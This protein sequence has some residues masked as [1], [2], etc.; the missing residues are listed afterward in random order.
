MSEVLGRARA[1]NL[2]EE[3]L[4]YAKADQTEVTFM[5]QRSSLTRFANNF[6]HQ[7][8]NENNLTIRV[9]AVYGQKIG[10]ATTNKL[11]KESLKQVVAEAEKLATLQVADPEFKSLPASTNSV[12]APE[13]DEDTYFCDPQV[14]ANGVG[15]ICRKSVEHN[16]TAAGAFETNGLEVAIGNSLGIRNYAR[17]AWSHLNT[18]VMGENSSGWGERMARRVSDIDCE[19]IAEEAVGKAERSRNPVSLEPGD[20]EVLL[21]EYAVA[22]LL[23][24]MSFLG[25]GGLSLQEHRSFMQIGQKLMSNLVTIADDSSHPETLV[26][27][28][29]A[30]GVSRQKVTLIEQGIAKGVVYDSY[31]ANREPGKVNTG[32]STGEQGEVG[33]VPFNLIMENG[34]LSKAEMLK[35]I[36]RGLYVTR[37]HYVNPLVPDKA[38]LTGMTRDGTFLIENGEIVGPVR[39]FRFTQSAVEALNNVVAVSRERKLLPFFGTMS[40]LAPA[41]HTAKFT[42]NSA[43]AF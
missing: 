4:G 15:A 40:T 20:Y 25:F 17:T 30:E 43:T 39:N 24:Y 6:I 13:P 11:D 37:F 28:F 38:V 16:F 33:P 1:L 31:T 12:E 27:P 3:V 18:V 36:K 35:N 2:L 7:N 23:N 32:H 19:E 21:E 34:S 29:D 26:N 22:D 9:R 8:V 14:R 41:I 42:F 5:G 10:T